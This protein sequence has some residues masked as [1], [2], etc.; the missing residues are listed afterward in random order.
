MSKIRYSLLGIT[1]FE[2][3]VAEASMKKAMQWL[4]VASH[5]GSPVTFFCSSC[6][7]TLYLFTDN[8]PAAILFEN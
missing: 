5:K 3:P 8:K 4:V 7:R 1:V 2:I 6:D